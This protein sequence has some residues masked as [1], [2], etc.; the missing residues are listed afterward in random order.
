[1]SFPPPLS[2]DIAPLLT[3]GDAARRLGVAPITIQRWVDAGLM[4]AARTEGGHRRIPAD[5]VVKRLR[6]ART[7]EQ[8]QRLAA[9]L[10]AL[11]AGD[12]FALSA[13]LGAARSQAT[14]WS[15]VADELGRVLVELGDLW[16]VG[17]CRV[18]E[19][20]VASQA[21]QRAAALCAARTLAK[22][23]SGATPAVAAAND[24]IMPAAVPALPRALLL[25][26]PGERHTLGLS[27][28]ELVLAGHGCAAVWIG[29][30]PPLAELPDMVASLRAEFCIVSAPFGA[31]PAALA[32]LQAALAPAARAAGTTLVLGGEARWRDDGVAHLCRRF[33]DLDALLTRHLPAR[34]D[35]AAR[36][37]P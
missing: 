17:T 19:E 12:A 6:L 22:V 7:A 27:L 35:E 33:A 23:T 28:V 20:H 36:E 14:S 1:M 4:R 32:S 21:L 30:G 5:E 16:S 25:T 3:V 34:A 37:A 24:E 13:Q 11:L 8:E 31:E 2:P 26:A 15:P 29:E 9:W 18:F 10:K